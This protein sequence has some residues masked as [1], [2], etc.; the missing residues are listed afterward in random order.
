[1]CEVPM[2]ML[3]QQRR[4]TMAHDGAEMP[5]NAG[6]ADIVALTGAAIKPVEGL[7]AEATAGLREQV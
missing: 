6:L 4:A 1:M 3:P 5:I 7:L 2:T